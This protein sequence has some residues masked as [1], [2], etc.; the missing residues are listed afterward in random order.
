MAV[1][2]IDLYLTHAR[3]FN[4]YLKKFIEG[5]IAVS[6]G[7]FLYIGTV[8]PPVQPLKT[9]D[10]AGKYVIPGMIDCHM[11]IESTMAAPHTFLQGSV[12][13]GVTTLIAEPHE[14]ANIFGVEGIR[15]LAAAAADGPAHVY[16]AIPS[17]VPSTN[18][19]LETTG[20][21]IGTAEVGDLLHMDQVICLG[22]VMNGHDLIA[23]DHSRISELVRQV[24][25]IRPDFPL[26]GHLPR[27]LD[28][29]LARIL[30]TGVNSDHTDQSVETVRQRIANGCFI[31]L[32]DK[33]LRPDIVRYI[34]DE[35][36]FEHMAIVTD[37]TM[38]DDFVKRGT[39][40]YLVQKA[41]KMGFTPEQAVYTTTYTPAR[42]M[43][44]RDRGSI[45]PGKVA[46]FVILDDLNDFRIC[47]TYCDGKEV[48][49]RNVPPVEEQCDT[50][51]PDRFYHSVHAAPMKEDDFVLHTEQQDGTVRCRL[52]VVS[53]DTTFVQSKEVEVPVKNHEIDWEDSPYNLAVVV[54][55]HGKNHGCGYALVGGNALKRGAAATTYAHD[56]HNLLIIGQNKRDMMTAA[57]AVIEAQ[58]G[59]AVAYHGDVKAFAP[60]PIA[61]ILSD[62]PL[63]VLGRQIQKVR[64][65][66]ESL[67]Y[68]HHNVIMSLSTLSLPV[69]P[70][71][72]LTDKGI[73]DVQKQ[74]IVP[75]VIGG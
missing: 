69:S 15:A 2:K 31:E 29:E 73:V 58:G 30:C 7:R 45:A 65:S 54:E 6:G 68:E 67:G 16:I 17:S 72:K 39:L 34:I 40:N 52:L 66:L 13:N 14:I 1:M 5:N 4:V 36:L 28:W 46:D 11:H 41:M 56:H 18:D 22:E 49:N 10:L 53:S 38:P 27:F 74:C 26:E 33:T 19:T 62:Q 59:Y 9:I 71:Y 24:R 43:G 70:F 75:L 42:R 35:N 51:F 44:L 63:P 3:I 23:D 21:V 48:Y 57:N 8:E 32:Q 20:A 50:S 60:L 47:S 25:H 12:K 64:A 37:D 61:G 55:R